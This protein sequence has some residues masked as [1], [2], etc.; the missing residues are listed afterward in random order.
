[1][2]LAIL[3]MKSIA[4]LLVV[5]SAIPFAIIF[6]I[7][8]RCLQNVKRKFSIIIRSMLAQTYD[9]NISQFTKD[10]H[11]NRNLPKLVLTYI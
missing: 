4:L 10:L 1:M 7:C 5:L 9:I 3:N 8:F 2:L 6:Q 11:T